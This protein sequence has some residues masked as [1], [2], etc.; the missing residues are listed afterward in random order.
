MS[1]RKNSLLAQ[2]L[3]KRVEK[4]YK[5]IAFPDLLFVLQVDPEIAVQR[6][7]D[8]DATFVGERAAEIWEMNWENID[9]HLIDGS[10]PKT[11]VANQ[12]KTLV[13]SGL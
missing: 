1:P 10:K 12:I 13:W 3:V 5:K 2:I 9:A 7:T 11:E 6:R 8:E 4:Y